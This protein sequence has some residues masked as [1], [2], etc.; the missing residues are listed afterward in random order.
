M[1]YYPLFINLAEADV[2]VVGSGAVGQRK[3]ASLAPALPRSITAVDPLLDARALSGLCP[4]VEFICRARPFAP[5]DIDGKSLVFAATSNR[6]TNAD[7]EALCRKRGILCN[8][9]DAPLAGSFIVPAHFTDGELTV[10]LSTGGK[11]PALARKLRREL[12][13]WLGTRYT[14]L[15]ALM[16]RLRPLLLQLHLPTEDNS[17]LFRALV[18][19]PLAGH[20]EIRDYASAEALLRRLLPEALHSRLGDLLHGH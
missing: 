19:S 20:L 13:E 7:V 12:E 10:A 6:A 16:G 1:G 18:E 17:A 2:L 15:L 4:N 11:S 3:I 5:T 14:P 9:A 8:S